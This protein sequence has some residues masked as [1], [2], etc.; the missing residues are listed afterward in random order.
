MKLNN[1]QPAEGS[2]KTGKRLGRGEGSARGGQCGRGM[3]GAKSRAGYHR[4]KG[5]EG[6]QMPIQR[7]LPKFGFKNP[8]RVEF[9]AVN[10]STLQALS[11]KL[12][13]NVIDIETLLQAKLISKNDN[14]KILGNGE[15]KSKL[16]VTANAFSKSAIDKIEALEGKATII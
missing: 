16:E 10:L 13:I 8:T 6:G 7:R 5:F 12:N 3:N 15:L 9:K 11:E 2:N 1:L 4:K 14:V